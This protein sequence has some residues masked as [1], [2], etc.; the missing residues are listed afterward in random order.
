MSKVANFFESNEVAVQITMRG[1]PTMILTMEEVLNEDATTLRQ[2]HLG[3]SKEQKEKEAHAHNAKLLG[4]LLTKPIE[5]P[6]P[7]M[8][9]EAKEL[10]A[11]FLDVKNPVAAKKKKDLLTNIFVLYWGSIQPEEFFR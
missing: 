4:M 11:F 2:A 10:E 7:G 1:Y 8:P 3:L 5:N 9:S 6:L